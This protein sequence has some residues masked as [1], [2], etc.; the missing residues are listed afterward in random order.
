MDSP[1]ATRSIATLADSMTSTVAALSTRASGKVGSEPAT[2]IKLFWGFV[3]SSMAIV[4]LISAGGKISGI[5]ATKQIATGKAHT[6]PWR[7]R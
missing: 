6:T 1:D 4:N 7:C 2:G 5:D 3:M